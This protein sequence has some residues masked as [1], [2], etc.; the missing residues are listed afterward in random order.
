MIDAATAGKVLKPIVLIYT[1]LGVFYWIY[2]LMTGEGDEGLMALYL[3]ESKIKGFY[4][5]IQAGNFSIPFSLLAYPLS[6]VFPSYL[7]LRISSLLGT[8]FLFFYLDKALNLKSK[9]FRIHL[10]FY[11]SSG[12]F[13]LGTNDNLLFCLLT[14]FFTEVYLVLVKRQERV[15]R[16]ALISMVTALFTRQMAVIY[17]PV[18]LAGLFLVYFRKK[19]YWKEY[20]SIIV[21]SLFWFGLNLPSI[22]ENGLI[23]FDNKDTKSQLGMTWVQRQYLS[24][25]AANDGKIPQFSHVTWEETYE[26]VKENGEESL[27]RTSLEALVFDP[28]L[29]LKEFIKDFGFMIYSGFR[30]CGLAVF[31]PV[32]GFWL[33]LKSGNKGIGYLSLSQLFM[34]LAISFIIISYVEIRWL[35]PVFIMGLI[36]IQESIRFKQVPAHLDLINQLTLLALSLYGSYRYIRLIQNTEVFQSFF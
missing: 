17:I 19:I 13:L 22:Q 31:F 25:L 3:D 29:T 15:P 2:F 6:L 9:N 12:S 8:V 5:L 24:Q 16:Y 14:V 10:L 4:W 28:I 20:Q 33:F 27:P 1:F 7:A 34:M 23:S 32:L 30:Q 11:L 18:I 36:G 35:G 21:S 26:Y